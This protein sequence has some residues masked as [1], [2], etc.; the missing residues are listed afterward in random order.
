MQEDQ[1]EKRDPQK[2]KGKLTLFLGCVRAGKSLELIAVG[3]R[4]SFSKK[5]AVVIKPPNQR[6]KN[7]VSSRDGS[8]IEAKESVYILDVIEKMDKEEYD[9]T[10]YFLIDEG[11]FIQDAPEMVPKLLQDGK[12]VFIAALNSTWQRTSWDVVSK[13]I[14]H[15]KKMLVFTAIC[16]FCPNSAIYS[17]KVKG[18]DEIIDLDD[19]RYLPACGG[20]YKEWIPKAGGKL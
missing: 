17:M 9:A 16:N 5:K 12:R 18:D 3:K 10:D 15:A 11:Q 4:V 20:C 8:S 7:L 2:K 1:K 19:E 14:P 13:L 6:A